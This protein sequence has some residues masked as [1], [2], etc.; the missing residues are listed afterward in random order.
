MKKKR[1]RPSN[2]EG[3]LIRMNNPLFLHEI[4]TLLAVR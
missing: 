2:Y 1:T 4:Q 3:A